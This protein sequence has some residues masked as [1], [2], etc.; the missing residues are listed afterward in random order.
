MYFQ[1]EAMAEAMA[2]KVPV[3]L[4]GN[5]FSGNRVEFKDSDSG[6]D[7]SQGQIVRS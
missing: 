4:A 6:F 5:V 3:A 7:R 2:E 1:T